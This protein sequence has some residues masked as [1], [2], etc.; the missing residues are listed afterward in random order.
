MPKDLNDQEKSNTI[1]TKPIKNSK[2]ITV[3]LN[4]IMITLIIIILIILAFIGGT[5]YQRNSRMNSLLNMNSKSLHMR[6]KSRLH[7][8]KTG[9]ITSINSNSI[10]IKTLRFGALTFNISAN[11]KFKS[12]NQP[13]TISNLQTGQT[14]LIKP[15]STSS[16]QA[17]L[18]IL[19]G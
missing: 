7:L 18:I 1:S 19:K 5:I 16:N 11:T 9:V 8:F 12:H 17:D 13:I 14:V 15:V 2:T 6:K 10:T 4:A 3:S